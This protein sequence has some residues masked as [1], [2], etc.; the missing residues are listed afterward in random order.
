MF[1]CKCNLSFGSAEKRVTLNP[2]KEMHESCW[3][4][5]LREIER[6][7]AEPNR[8]PQFVR[9]HHKPINAQRLH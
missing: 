9:P 7:A 8:K 3:R 5:H 2:N 4:Q 1:C 6:H